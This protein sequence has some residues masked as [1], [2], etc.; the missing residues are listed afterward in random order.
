[1]VEKKTFFKFGRWLKI[2]KVTD[3]QRGVG[4]FSVTRGKRT[5]KFYEDKKTL[6]PKDRRFQYST[7][8]LGKLWELK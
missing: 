6:R 8:R 5:G 3:R 1:M 2:E 4:Y 7:R